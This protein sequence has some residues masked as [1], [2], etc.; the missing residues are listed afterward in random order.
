MNP[1]VEINF[2]SKLDSLISEGEIIIDRPKGSAHPR[3]PQIIYSLDY[4]YIK[5]THSSDGDDLDIWLGSHP[6]QRLD[7]VI[8]AV[9][10]NKRDLEV[11]LLIGCT[12]SEKS[13]IESFYNKWSETGGILIER[14][15]SI[16]L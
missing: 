16:I 3:Y 5:D 6:D 15:I 12:S 8:C 9:D 10:L 7:A 4:G 13:Y 11:K 1:N 14:K 2:W